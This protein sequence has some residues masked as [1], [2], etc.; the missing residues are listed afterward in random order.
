MRPVRSSLLFLA[1]SLALALGAPAG[2]AQ[3]AGAPQGAAPFKSPTAADYPDFSGNNALTGQ[4]GPPPRTADGR[5]DLTGFWEGRGIDRGFFA[6][7]GGKP[8]FTKGV[9]LSEFACME[10]NRDLAHMRFGPNVD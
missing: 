10:N 2:L 7:V 1:A 4:S 8:P 3:P 9:E 6:G 5:P